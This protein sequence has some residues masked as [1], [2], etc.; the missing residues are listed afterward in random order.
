MINEPAYGPRIHGAAPVNGTSEVQT[1]TIDASGGTFK[2]AFEGRKTAAISWSGTNTTLRDAVDA[3]LEALPNIGTCVV[4]VAVGTMTNGVGTLTLT[5]AGN[6]AKKAVAT[7]TVAD[8]S[9][10]GTGTLTVEETTPGVDATHRGA[11][12]GA[13]LID[14]NAGK[15]YIYTGTAREPTW[16]VVGSQSS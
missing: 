13:L 10:E 2:L 8:N 4:T 9:L 11:P 6:L 16:T 14:T 15:L 12:K 5:F 7:V 1:L 3:A